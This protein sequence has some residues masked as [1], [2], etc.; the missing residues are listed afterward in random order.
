M[1][2]LDSKIRARVAAVALVGFA[3]LP[4]CTCANAQYNRAYQRE[5]QGRIED[6]VHAGSRTEVATD[7]VAS[8]SDRGFSL[9]AWDGHDEA[10]TEWLAR[11][12]EGRERYRATLDPEDGGWEVILVHQLQHLAEPKWASKSRTRDQELS[13][14]VLERVHPGRAEGMTEAQIDA[15]AYDVAPRILWDAVVAEVGTRRHWFDVHE[16]PID[17]TASTMWVVENTEPMS[18]S[19]FEVQLGRSAGKSVTMDVH[20]TVEVGEGARKWIDDVNERDYDAELG[21]IRR[22]DSAAAADIE[23]KAHEQGQQAYERAVA[24]RDAACDVH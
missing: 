19:R 17:V 20:R 11:G 22:R 15:F 18:R 5:L 23:A 1:L 3:A 10:A 16:P 6:Y 14:A 21:L 2:G 12:D 24:R 4:N 7:V 9:D 13:R 8:L